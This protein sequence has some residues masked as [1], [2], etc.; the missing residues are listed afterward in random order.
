MLANIAKATPPATVTALELSHVPV[1][2]LIQ[3]GTLVYVTCLCVQMGY[4]GVCFVRSKLQGRG[5][6]S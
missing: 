6:A 2:E 4:K 1:P 5:G 3:I